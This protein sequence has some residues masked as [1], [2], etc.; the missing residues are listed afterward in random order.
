[1]CNDKTW[2]VMQNL[3]D[4]FNRL[5]A[6]DDMINDLQT[7]VNTNDSVAIKNVAD[8]MKAFMPVYYQQYDKASKRAWNNTV[9]AT[10]PVSYDEEVYQAMVEY[11]EYENGGVVAS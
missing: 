10:P 5:T 8:A 4:S 1:M 7:A 6:I 9:L 3:E 11:D 2:E